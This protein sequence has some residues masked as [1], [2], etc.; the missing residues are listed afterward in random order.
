M[1]EYVYDQAWREERERLRG[2]EALWD[3]GTEALME[4]LGLQ[5][6]WRCLE[7][8]AGGGSIA[9]WLAG[10]V[11][12]GGEVLATDVTTRYLDAIDEPN[13]EAREHDIR[14]DPLPE[15]HFDLV[16][17]RLVVEH[18]GRSALEPMV[19]AVRPGGVL[20]LEDYD[21]SSA[22]TH[23]DSP[24]L[25]RALEAVLEFMSRAGFD[26]FYGRKMLDELASA[27]LEDVAAEGRS[28]VY[29]GASTGTAFARLSLESLRGAVVEAGL[30]TDDEVERALESI[31]NPAN[32]FISPTIVAAWGR[33]PS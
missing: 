22:V 30:V 11:G 29:R 14:S 4:R 26:P 18:L 7:V 6:G 1:G 13:L 17:A 20:L 16:H 33:R 25:Q 3:P 19:A 8:G 31:D 10:R 21:F 28:R 9:E 32:A 15:G 23:P 24:D 27:G 2:M 12:A 5:P